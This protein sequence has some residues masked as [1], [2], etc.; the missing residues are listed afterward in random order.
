M[1]RFDYLALLGILMVSCAKSNSPAGDGP[2][3][4]SDNPGQEILQAVPIRLSS[5]EK[6]VAWSANEFGKKVFLHLLGESENN[7]DIIFSPFSLSLDL[8]LCAGGASGNTGTQI[9]SALGFSDKAPEDVAGYYQTMSRSL[10]SADPSVRFCSAN[11]IWVDK[12]LSLKEDYMDYAH[13]FFDVSIR[14]LDL[15]RKESLSQI[16][17]WCKEATEGLVEKMLDDEKDPLSLTSAYLLNALYFN[18]SWSDSFDEQKKEDVFHGAMGD[19]QATYL[20]GE[21]YYGYRETGNATLA[22]IGYGSGLFELV[23]AIPSEGTAMDEMLL[24]LTVDDFFSLSRRDPVRLTLPEFEISFNTEDALIP[25][26]KACGI[27]DAFD[28]RL[29]DFSGMFVEDEAFKMDQVLQQ[30]VIRVDE[31]GTE[32][33]AVTVIGM[34]YATGEPYVP[35]LR[36]FNANRPF[37]FAL[38]EESSHTVLFWGI[39]R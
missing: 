4:P 11:S 8:A 25:A 34:A 16:N 24:N 7:K 23:L 21:Q 26:L 38:V 32:S 37:L 20:S 27:T 13:S 1:K 19:R 5:P 22:S 14:S 33:A 12:A 17:Q 2:A 6:Q 3:A 29:A 39:K 30:S 28:D 18:G 35:V 10:Q 31:K 15:S 36:T 9:Y